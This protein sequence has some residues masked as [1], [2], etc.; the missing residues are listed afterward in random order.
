MRKIIVITTII[1]IALV[2]TGC[3]NGD[4]ASKPNGTSPKTTPQAGNDPNQTTGSTAIVAKSENI[5][6][7][8]DKAELL[9]QVDKELDSLFNNMNNLDDAQDADLELNQK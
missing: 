7:S 6:S 8:S 4:P 2:L 3:G 9:S 1:I 5:V